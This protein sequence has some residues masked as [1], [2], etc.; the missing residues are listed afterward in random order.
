MGAVE[1]SWEKAMEPLEAETEGE[2][3]PG[4]ELRLEAWELEIVER[5]FLSHVGRC[6]RVAVGSKSFTSW[7]AGPLLSFVVS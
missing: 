6:R 4:L 3:G 2:S 5:R 7:S 1:P